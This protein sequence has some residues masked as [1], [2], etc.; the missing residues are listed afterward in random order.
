MVLTPKDGL[1]VE[2]KLKTKADVIAGPLKKDSYL[3]ID[4]KVRIYET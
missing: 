4:K 1:E 2:G 3:I